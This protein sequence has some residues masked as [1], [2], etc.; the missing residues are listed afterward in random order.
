MSTNTWSTYLAA[1]TG[2]AQHGG[3]VYTVEFEGAP[4]VCVEPLG[5]DA[6]CAHVSTGPAPAADEDNVDHLTSLLAANDPGLNASAVRAIDPVTDQLLLFRRWEANAACGLEEFV[7]QLGMFAR[8][9]G[10]S[11]PTAGEDRMPMRVSSLEEDVFSNIWADYVQTFQLGSIHD[12]PGKRGHLIA[13]QDGGAVFVR[14][15]PGG[16]V[17]VSA[18]LSFLPLDIPDEANVLRRLLEAH[19]LG[20]ATAGACFAITADSELTAYRRLPLTGLTA[21]S[22]EQEINQIAATAAHF[23]SGFGLTAPLAG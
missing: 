19:L 3:G 10:Q 15:E 21:A 13:T 12:A 14:A 7:E 8:E 16:R 23:V 6:L 1:M 2:G 20:E 5:G 11:E 4:A 9:A 18:V 17:L 22:L